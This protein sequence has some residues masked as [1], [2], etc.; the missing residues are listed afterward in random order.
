MPMKKFL[1]VIFY[2]ALLI[3][4]SCKNDNTSN[5]NNSNVIQNNDSA[6]TLSIVGNKIWIRSEQKTGKV[7]LQL[8]EGAKCILLEKGE[9]QT[10]NG[11]TDYWYKI[12]YNGTQGWV[13]GSQTSLQQNTFISDSEQ[14]KNYI[15]YFVDQA[16]KKNYSDL[17]N[18][19]LNDNVYLIS[20]PG[21][22]LVFKKF[23]YKDGLKQLQKIKVNPQ[24]YFDKVPQFDMNLYKWN[25]T[26]IFIVNIENSKEISVLLENNVTL[27][28]NEK[29]ELVDL[30]KFLVFKIIITQGDGITIYVCKIADKLKIIAFNIVTNDA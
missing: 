22:I 15:L 10:I 28:N 5:E 11:V 21:A 16:N 12:D 6:Q 2:L 24:I 9:L 13:F 27:D 25:D 4:V 14:I 17:R 8:D 30:Q 18:Y 3:F 29:N 20:N 26:G 1:S 19:F 7:I 23:Y